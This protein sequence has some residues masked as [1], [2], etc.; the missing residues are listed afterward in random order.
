M[1]AKSRFRSIAPVVGASWRLL[2]QRRRTDN[3]GIGRALGAA[4]PPSLRLSRLHLCLRVP[5]GQ[6]PRRL[7][8]HPHW[9]RGGVS[10]VVDAT[11][12]EVVALHGSS[13]L[14]HAWPLSSPAPQ[15]RRVTRP[16]AAIS[17]GQ[18]QTSLHLSQALNYC[19]NSTFPSVLQ[20]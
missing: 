4:L 5:Q 7:H 13:R 6:S 1:P 14:G 11:S 3:G 18:W 19:L 17:T 20:G 16:C 15:L 2:L 12:D 10:V 8:H 9:Q